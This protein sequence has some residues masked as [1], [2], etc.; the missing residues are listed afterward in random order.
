MSV[1]LSGLATSR[2]RRAS[3]AVGS[4]SY[5]LR[6]GRMDYRPS[7]LAVAFELKV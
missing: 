4:V 5:G 6:D 3:F 1:S 7:R 2:T